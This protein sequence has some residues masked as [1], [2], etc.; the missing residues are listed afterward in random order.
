M[1]L[2]RQDQLNLVDPETPI[3]RNQ[4]LPFNFAEHDPDDVKRLGQVLANKMV[5]L[6]GVGL[7][8]NQVGLPYRMFVMGTADN[9]VV[10]V[11]PE[12]V[13]FRGEPDTFRE[14][15][16]SYPGLQMYIKRPPRILVRYQNVEGELRELEYA[17][18]S[19]RIFQH[20]YEH[21]QGRDFTVGASKLKLRMAKERYEKQRKQLIRKHALQTLLKAHE[22]GQKH[23][24]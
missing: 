2:I 10:I 21:M 4:L 18:L 3:M 8:A 22:D 12:I 15:C 20:E 6:G 7:S 14:G 5:E 19:A 17:G 1:I 23:T 16:L 13:E 11:N 24:G 9:N